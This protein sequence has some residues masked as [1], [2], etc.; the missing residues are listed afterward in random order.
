MLLA[1]PLLT[2]LLPSATTRTG[3]LIHVYDQP[4]ELSLVPRG[5]PLTK[6][7]MMALNS[8]NRLASTVLL[9]GGITPITA[10][11]LI[12]GISWTRWLIL[13]SVPYYVILVLGA[14]LIYVRYRRGG[15]HPRIH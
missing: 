5:A 9:T 7:I 11:A 12:G 8:I 4:L 6:A 1:F 13:L 2:F 15:P 10:A 14:G 3:I